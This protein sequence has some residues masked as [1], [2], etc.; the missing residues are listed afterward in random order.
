MHPAVVQPAGPGTPGCPGADL[1]R[2][3]PELQR[4]GQ[5][6][7]SS[8]L[9]APRTWCG[10]AGAGRPGAGALAG[11]GDRPAGDPQGRWR[12]CAAGP[13]IP[14]GSPALHDRGQRH[15]P[16]A[17][18]CADVPGPRR[19][20]GRRGALV[21]GG[22]RRAAGRLPGQRIAFG[23][24]AATPGLPDLHLRFYRP[25]QGRGGVPW[26]NRH[27]LPG[28]DPSIRHACRRLRTALLF[29]QLRRRYRALAG[30]AAQ[31][32]PGGAAGPGPV[33]RRGN[34]PADPP[35]SGQHPGLYPQ[36]WQP[37]GPAPGDPAANPGGT[38][39]HHRWRSFDR[40]APATHSR[41]LPAEP[42]LQRLRSDRNRGHAPGQPGAGTIGRRRGQRAHRPHRRRAGGLYPRCRPGSGA[43]RRDR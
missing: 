42:V 28:G 40:R 35:A 30:A 33:G 17:Q 39:V 25:A 26:G 3:D 5:P 7:Q 13:G 23:Q 22:G 18:R 14:L 12:L 38:H 24:P 34:L 1:R 37:T 32:C 10:P 29:H 41:G 6:R 20:A 36:L 27:A 43:P 9:D 11:D 2:P 31:R 16:A 4:A 8:G 21:P 15:R 19:T